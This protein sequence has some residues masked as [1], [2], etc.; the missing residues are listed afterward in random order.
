MPMTYLIKYFLCNG[1]YNNNDH[2][3][4]VVSEYIHTWMD[5]HIVSHVLPECKL[6][7]CVS[8]PL[9]LMTTLV[10]VPSSQLRAVQL[11][12]DL[13]LRTCWYAIIYQRGE[14]IMSQLSVLPAL[15][16]SAS[17]LMGKATELPQPFGSLA[18]L[19][20][21]MPSPPSLSAS[22][23]HQPDKTTATQVRLFSVM[24]CP[25]LGWG[26]NSPGLSRLSIEP[27]H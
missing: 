13:L 5:V 22:Q 10:I 15:L 4:F 11:T 9:F 1:N 27:S 19:F 3:S 8:F 24:K 26:L 2:L 12:S 20:K 14:W 23:I 16:L 7:F 21:S 6:G 17:Y 18:Y 25:H